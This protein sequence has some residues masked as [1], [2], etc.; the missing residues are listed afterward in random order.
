MRSA[1][2]AATIAVSQVEAFWGTSHLLVSRRAQDLLQ[3]Q[4]NDA[5][6][7]VLA[8]LAPLKENYPSLT[9]DEG[10]HPMTECATFADNIKGQGYSFQAPWHFKDQPYYP[11]GVKSFDEPTENI[12][13]ALSCFTEWLSNSGTTYQDSYYYKTVKNYFP[14]EEDARSFALRLIIHYAGDIHQPLHATT[15]VS[16]A[17]PNGD[18][19]GNYEHL[20][21]ICG[22]SN[23]HAVW[24]SLA[25]KYCG[26]V[27]L[28]MTSDDW[29]W[30]SETASS[31]A[32][33][34]PIDKSQMY[35]GDFQ[36][37]ATL[38]Y[39]IATKDVYPV[40]VNEKLS[41]EYVAN[42]VEILSTQVMYGG[43]RLNNLMQQIYGNKSFETTQ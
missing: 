33:E 7:A 37:W 28:P 5:Y 25:Y 41:A 21:N 30:Y 11:D 29:T 9:E 26:F 42:A 4:D 6:K 18:A 31:L 20:P 38:S 40:V 13:D 19:G 1:L 17:Y 10:D 43:Y 24:D 34:Y 12:V 36:Q 27:D 8:E 2:I 39:E 15:E 32:H 22:A 23:L 3:S 16:N 14:D 35:D